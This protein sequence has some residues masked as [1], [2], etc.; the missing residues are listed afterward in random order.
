[1]IIQ[2][3]LFFNQKRISGPLRRFEEIKSG[4]TPSRKRRRT[5]PLSQYISFMYLIF[6][7]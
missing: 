7:I 2:G 3:G 4:R 5:P 6:G 1:M